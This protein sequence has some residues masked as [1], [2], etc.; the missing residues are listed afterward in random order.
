MAECMEGLGGRVSVEMNNCLLT[1]FT[2]KEVEFALKYIQPLKL[3]RSDGFAVGFYQNSWH[4]VGREVS[5]AVLDFLNSRVF[6]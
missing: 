5:A 4:I 1:P 2:T 6:V 3:P